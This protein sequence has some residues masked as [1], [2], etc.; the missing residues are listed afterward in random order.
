MNKPSITKS[1]SS[2]EPLSRFETFTNLSHSMNSSLL[3]ETLRSSVFNIKLTDL[4][5]IRSQIQLLT[6]V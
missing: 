4:S 6:F 2:Q 5:Q 1:D 3:H